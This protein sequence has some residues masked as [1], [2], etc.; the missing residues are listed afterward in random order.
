MFINLETKEVVSTEEFK[1][2]HR[3]F[4]LPADY[5]NGDF[6]SK[7][8]AYIKPTPYPENPNGV[9]TQGDPR[10]DEDGNAWQTWEIR[11]YTEEELEA[12]KPPPK[13]Y[14]T[15]KARVWD[16]DRVSDEDFDALDDAVNSLSRRLSNQWRDTLYLFHEDEPYLTVRANLTGVLSE[17]KID[18]IFQ[19]D[20]FE[21][22]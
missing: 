21:Q 8:Y 6:S 7:G 12:M 17:E 2:R 1:A 19:Q 14:Y 22:Y 15:E 11:P 3:N 4:V 18:R 5:Y 10:I 13:R 16:Q 9:V 20:G